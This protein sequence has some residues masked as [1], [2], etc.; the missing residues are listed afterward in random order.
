M[1]STCTWKNSQPS[2]APCRDAAAGVGT[3]LPPL[4]GFHF[5]CHPSHISLAHCSPP[6]TVHPRWWPQPQITCPP[7]SL[8]WYNS[9]S[10]T[11]WWQS[12]LDT[13]SGQCWNS[14]KRWRQRWSLWGICIMWAIMWK[15]GPSPVS[16][17]CIDR[18]GVS[19]L[20]TRWSWGR[21]LRTFWA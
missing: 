1:L 17:I 21:I 5:Y 16:R 3:F 18:S 14:G 10:R 9:K 13:R 7:P 15:C 11:D 12:D 20:R 8:Q 19:S 2:P 6:L 4:F